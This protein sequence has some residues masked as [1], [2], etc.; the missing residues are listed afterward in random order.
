MD[1]SIFGSI[2]GPGGVLCRPFCFG[3]SFFVWLRSFFSCLPFLV[4][5]VCLALLVRF[6]PLSCASCAVKI[7]RWGVTKAGK[8]GTPATQT[9]DPPSKKRPKY[10]AL[11]YTSKP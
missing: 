8:E 3:H 10:C 4:L 9:T 7:G 6:L 5:M 1:S 2:L 11:L